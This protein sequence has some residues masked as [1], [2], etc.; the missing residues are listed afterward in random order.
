ME[1]F[2]IVGEYIK[3]KGQKAKEAA[4]ELYLLQTAKKNEA[5]RSMAEAIWENQTAILQANAADVE[6]ARL[7][8]QPEGRIDRLILSEKRL[9]DMLEG[10]RQIAELPDPVGERLERIVRPDGLIIENVRVPIGVIGII[11]ESRPNV[12][13]DAA[14]L[15]LKTGDAVILRGGKEA[16]RTNQTL[17]TALR[18]G[19]ERVG[20]NP[21][22]V[23]F[24]DRIERE[25]VDSLIRMREYIDLVI[26][27][28]GAGL[29]R[30]VVEHATVPVV[31]TGVGN[32]HVY[33]D[34][35]ADLEKATSIV[36]N[37]KTQRPSVCNAMETL[38]VHQAV[39]TRWLP[40]IVE[41]LRAEGVQIRGCERTFEVLESAS[42][43]SRGTLP[44]WFR[45]ATEED[46]ET[47]FLDLILAVKVV[48]SFAEA[49]Q[50][51]HRYSTFHSEAII[52]EN[53]T[54]AGHFL[55]QIDA[56]AVYHNAS[57]RFTDGFE[58]GFG[59]EIG[60]ST[61]KLHA[62]GPM[63]LKELTSSKYVI[64]GNGH[65]RK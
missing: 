59:A 17:V 19:L 27:R 51:I 49:V 37:A 36:M 10:L 5:L 18:T 16:L 46:W 30:R 15:T 65:I 26:P 54:T 22:A 40:E 24:I 2:A 41:R 53:Q 50:H 48:E 45:P 56:A 7:A 57:T 11:Y 42:V 28:G 38:L 39:A 63:G 64:R 6:D 47:E 44:D 25:T 8:G 34:A 1:T 32:C 21:D 55:E 29:I 4:R 33:V 31:E 20:V 23:Q 9:A 3:A 43:I 61:Q 52:T 35:E 58:F 13:V 12:T 14:G 62:R 60:I